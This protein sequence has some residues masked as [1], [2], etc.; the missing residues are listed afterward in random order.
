M[1]QTLIV[2]NTSDNVD[3]RIA[4]LEATIAEK[5][6][7]LNSLRVPATVQALYA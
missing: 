6:A 2:S 7:L 5:L 1:N 4:R 3:E